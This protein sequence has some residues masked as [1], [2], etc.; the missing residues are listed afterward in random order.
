MKN[1]LF[2]CLVV[3]L[4]LT[5]FTFGE[6]TQKPT[7]KELIA[8]LENMTTVLKEV[9]DLESARTAGNKLS[10]WQQSSFMSTDPQL[11]EH[12]QKML[13]ADED[14]SEAFVANM[15]EMQ[16]IETLGK[17]IHSEVIVFLTGEKKVDFAAQIEKTTAIINQIK[18][19][20]DLDRLGPDLTLSWKPIAN[21]MMQD[22]E[23]AMEFLQNNPALQ[24]ALANHQVVVE[25]IN[26][27][28]PELAQKVRAAM[29]GEELLAKLEKIQL[30]AANQLD[31]KKARLAVVSVNA[32]IRNMHDDNNA[33]LLTSSLNGADAIMRTDK[34]LTDVIVGN[35]RENNPSGKNYLGPHELKNDAVV[36]PWG[37]PLR[38]IIDT[39][40]DGMVQEPAEYG[41]RMMK[42]K[43]LVDSAGADGDFK[44][45]EDNWCSWEVR[46]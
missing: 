8:E 26:T 7:T 32:A 19:D 24:T 13:N 22:L 40:G 27:E 2:P 44:T 39:N 31:D 5:S 37:N 9:I 4:I 16:R 12:I 30:D 41:G 46:Q 35:D 6:D 3:G 11:R 14:L 1:R 45:I 18:T 20:D 33:H 25:R 10:E 17:Q 34:K 23:A 28:S 38:V 29:L 15:Q 42:D 36:D 43:S 21:M